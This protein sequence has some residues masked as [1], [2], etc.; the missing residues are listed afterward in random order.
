MDSLILFLVFAGLV[1]WGVGSVILNDSNKGKLKALY[2]KYAAK[3]STTLDLGG[4]GD[5]SGMD[6][7]MGN[8][9]DRRLEALQQELEQLKIQAERDRARIETLERLIT[10]SGYQTREAFR[11]M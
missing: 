11:K 9:A 3:A 5:D 10:D 2:D 1:L 6:D 4:M 7:G 8:G